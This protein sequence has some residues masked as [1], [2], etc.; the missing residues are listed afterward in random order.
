MLPWVSRL[1]GKKEGLVVAELKAHR[2]KIAEWKKDVV[3][4]VVFPVRRDLVVLSSN[5]D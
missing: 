2:G 5:L 3:P 4:S 1:Q